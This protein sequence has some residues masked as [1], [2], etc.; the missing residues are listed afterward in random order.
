ML[1][2]PESAVLARQ[3]MEAAGGRT[4]R[5][6]QAAASPHKFAWYS[7]DPAEYP[8]R[9]SS[10]KITSCVSR[11]GMV[12]IQAEEMRIALGDG[13]NL[14]WL[15][16]GQARPARHQLL[17]VL[18]DGSLLAGSVQMYGGILA[19]PAGADNNPYYQA[20]LTKPS[21]QSPEFDPKYFQALRSGLPENLSLKAFLATGQR[22]PGLG[23]GVLQDILFQAQMNPRRPIRT[24]QE[25]DWDI[26]YESIRETLGQMTQ[27]GGRDT[28]KDL[29][30]R[31]G[32]YRTILCKNTAGQPCTRCHA[33]IRKETYLGGSVYFCPSCQK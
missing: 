23:N 32:G 10:K 15:E 14:R 9:L 5:S 27:R 20:A 25:P 24:L 21:P 13:V 31:P 29:F 18:D 26:L 19:F 33:A 16:P 2:I 6:V 4:I 17:L 1:E 22:I 12:E 28:E 3:I 7:G 30:G 11:G 8:N